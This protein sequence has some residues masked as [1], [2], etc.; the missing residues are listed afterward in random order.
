V[1]LF[2]HICIHTE[3][4]ELHVLNRAGHYS[5]REQ[6]RAFNAVLRAFSLDSA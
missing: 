6:P 2:E 4:A 1:R 3:R 5:F